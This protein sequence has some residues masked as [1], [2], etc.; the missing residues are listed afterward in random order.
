MTETQQAAS[1]GTTAEETT[2]DAAAAEAA[3]TSAQEAAQASGAP[4]QEADAPR[5][6]H[7]RPADSMALLIWFFWHVA[8]YIYMVLA[9]PGRT[10]AP[11]LD[12]L[13]PWDSDNFI[14][15]AQYGYDG[16]PGMPDA[17]KLTAFFPGLPLFLRVLHVVVSDWSLAIV[18]VTLVGSAVVAV[19]LSRLG[20]S[21]REGSGTWTVLAFFLSPFAVFMLAGYSEAPFLALAVPAWLLARRGR[22]EAA[23]V[24]AAFASSVRIS[25]LFLAAGLAVAFLV[26]DNGLRSTG[27]R[28]A[29]WL[30]VPGLPVLAYMLYLWHRTGMPMAWKQAEADYWGRFPEKPWTV[31]LNTWDRSLNEPV[32]QTSYREEM[33]AAGV[34]VALIVWQVVRRRWADF[35]YLAPQAVALLAMSSF[36]MSVGRASLLWWPLYLSVGVTAVRRPWVFMAYLAVAAPVMAINVG[37]F[38]TGAWVG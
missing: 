29:P 10:D 35:A 32:L 16:S 27:W 22:W 25:G 36:Y 18:L 34:L 4:G 13:T 1:G 23:A 28:K 21:Y 12:R 37:N 5:W 26:S 3:Q 6:W 30:L 9:A 2:G 20:E 11:M 7:L 19:A 24:C 33:I 15:I 31:F 8:T 17:P 38:T 14:T